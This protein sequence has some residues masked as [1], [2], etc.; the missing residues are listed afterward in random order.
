MKRLFEKLKIKK[1][2]SKPGKGLKCCLPIVDKTILILGFRVS[3][4]SLLSYLADWL[5]YGLIALIAAILYHSEPLLQEFSLKDRRIMYSYYPEIKLMV[6]VWALIICVLVIPLIISFLSS[7]FSIWK[8]PRK[9]WDAHIF[10]L[11]LI[12]ALAFQFFVTTI[13]KNATGKPRPDFLHRCKPYD[14]TPPLAAYTSVVY[15]FL[16]NA[17]RF[18]IFD[19]RGL[20]WKFIFS[21]IPLCTANFVS[22]AGIS[23]NRNFLEDVLFGM[24][25]GTIIGWIFYRMY[26]PSVFD[27]KNGGKAYPPRRFGIPYFSS[28]ASFYPFAQEMALVSSQQ[29]EGLPMV[30]LRQYCPPPPLPPPPPVPPPPSQAPVFLPSIPMAPNVIVNI[31]KHPNHF[32]HTKDHAEP[33]KHTHNGK[34]MPKEDLLL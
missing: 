10:A 24:L 12:G 17:G 33:S 30:E 26:F 16:Y 27:T 19:G 29:S 34:H 31:K 21:V 1:R 13:I 20:S 2:R 14:Y 11:G 28:S 25:L 3:L 7:I 6:P 18:R 22:F 23:D 32:H 5:I 4:L 15:H 9:L 8:W